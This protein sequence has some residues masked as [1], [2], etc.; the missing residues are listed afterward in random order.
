MIWHWP[1]AQGARKALVTISLLAC[2]LLL[3]HYWRR[4]QDIQVVMQDARELHWHGLRVAAPPG[5][6]LVPNSAR[7]LLAIVAARDTA[8]G[9]SGEAMGFQEV[10]EP[11]HSPYDELERRCRARGRCE[12]VADSILPFVS[13]LKDR[14]S[15]KY[16][17]ACRAANSQVEGYFMGPDSLLPMFFRLFR[18]A[19]TRP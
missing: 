18:E 14:F 8:G 6:T 1:K 4:W 5:Y 16:L 2:G 10:T 17:A 13:C 9:R 19:H 15:R 3:V 12:Q 11:R 7:G